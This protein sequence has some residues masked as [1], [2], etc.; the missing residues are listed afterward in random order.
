MQ[1]K[2]KIER[3]NIVQSVIIRNLPYKSQVNVYDEPEL[4]T[5][6]LIMS[7]LILIL[8]C[9]LVQITLIFY[10]NYNIFA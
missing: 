5:C 6:S 8:I 9:I 3:I 1:Y 2:D 10:Y 4:G 7:M